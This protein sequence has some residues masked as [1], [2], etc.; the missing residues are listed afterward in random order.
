[1]AEDL[2]ARIRLGRDDWAERAFA[3][4]RRAG[5]S[6]ETLLRRL[7]SS[8]AKPHAQA[9][10]LTCFCVVAAFGI[11]LLAEA[12]WLFDALFLAGQWGR[13]IPMARSSA[14]AI[15]LLS[16]GVFAHARWSAHRLSRGVAVAA[17]VLAVLAALLGLL[18]PVTF[19]PGLN[20]GVEWA[21]FRMPPLTAAAVLLESAALLLLLY[22]TRWRFADSV[23]AVLAVLGTAIALVVLVGCAYGA[24]LLYGDTRIPMA[25]PAAVAIGLVGIGMSRLALPGAPALRAWRGN[26][27]RG[28]LLRAFLPGVLL[29]IFLDGWLDSMGWTT[30]AVNPALG[31][32]L[33]AIVLAAVMVALTARTARRTGDAIEQVQGALEKSRSLHAESDRMGKLGG[34][35]FDIDAQELVWT[36]EIYRI[37]E[38]DFNYEPT[39]SKAINF[40]TPASRPIIERAVQRAIEHAEPFDAELEIVT[41]K[42]N[43]RS[44]H[45]I[46][47]AD[48]ERHKLFGFLQDIT[49]RKRAHSALHE[50]E[51]HL[52]SIYNTVGDVIFYLAVEPERQFRFVSV[53]AAFLR[54]TGLTL[55]TVVGKT[56]N[57]IIPEPSL[58]MVL[59]KY[60]QAIAGN[61]IVRWEETSDYPAG[62]LTGE[63][64]VAPVFDDK[65]ACTHLVGSVHDITERKRAEEERNSLQ[66]QLVQSQQMESIGRLAGGL[67]HDFGNL[68]GVILL[69]GESALE[70]LRSGDLLVKPLSEIQKAAKRA[71]VLSQ[72]LMAFSHKQVPQA[73]VLNLNSVIA[74]NEGLV[75][76]L[77]RED[78]NLVFIPGSDLG[79]VKADPGQLGQIIVNLAMNSRDAMPEGGKLIIET[80]NV[81][82]DKG[83][84]RLSPEAKPGS[85]VM[86]AVRDTGVGMDEETKDRV[87]EPFFTTKDVGKGTGLGLWMVYAIVQQ[88]GGYITVH[89]EPGRG[90]EFR[91]YLPAVLETLQPV[92]ATEGA[93]ERGG[94]ETILVAEDEPALREKVCELLEDA[95]YQV[96]VGKNPDEVIQI[97]MQHKGPPDLLLADVVMPD[98]SGPQLA[99]HLQRVH[100]QIKVLYMSG[101]P[102]RGK[103]NSALA[104][105]RDFIQKPFTKQKLLG[106]LREVLDGGRVSGQ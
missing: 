103:P 13:N 39:V 42:G 89:S 32:F 35:E 72:Q 6:G 60:R 104:P 47:K 92:L 22:G 86:L 45:A 16:S 29:I 87:F 91:I 44:V 82:L 93:P 48:G 40:Y 90:A 9:Q 98:L 28:I 30:A 105:D 78:I 21:L 31:H 37:H 85:Y 15:L 17:A 33:E 54:V 57:E 96:L 18:T 4:V 1:M 73:E 61:A 53:N 3:A 106:R 95:G 20:S 81:E 100:P 66:L 2:Q 43:L 56:V 71:V 14:L 77:I 63:V 83:D 62:R 26:S 7:A 65:G 8:V 11:A 80:T 34:W 25:L 99:Q 51:Q 67:A 41:A 58:T 102:D 50:N 70:E 38:V 36:E 79:L 75:Q 101:Y 88:S 49:E 68:M 27:T 64:S 5:S 76:S 12:G 97:A 94:V 46:G 19:L 24:P 69:H 55:E 59:G 10:R 84:A 23:A 74:E 52:V